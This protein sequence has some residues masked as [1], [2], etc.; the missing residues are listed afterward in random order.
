[1]FSIEALYQFRRYQI[2]QEAASHDV[3]KTE[4][5]RVENAASATIKQAS[6]NHKAADPLPPTSVETKKAPIIRTPPEETPLAVATQPPGKQASENHKAADPQPLPLAPTSPET[7]EAPMVKTIRVPV[8]APS[9]PSGHFWQARKPLHR[10]YADFPFTPWTT[11]SIPSLLSGASAKTEEKP[12]S[13]PLPLNNETMTCCHLNAWL[14]LV[15]TNPLLWNIYS[16]SLST[17]IDTIPMEE[18]LIS[19]ATKLCDLLFPPINGTRRQQDVAETI[20]QF[21]NHFENRTATAH[22][23]IEKTY[24][25]N[26]SFTDEMIEEELNERGKIYEKRG[27]D[28]VIFEEE[29]TP[30]FPFLAIS[31][32]PFRQ[33][34]FQATEKKWMSPQKAAVKGDRETINMGNT[35]ILT[36][37]EQSTRFSHAPASLI[38]HAERNTDSVN[39]N[40]G[41]IELSESMLLPGRFFSENT[42][43]QYQLRGFIVHLSHRRPNGTYSPNDGHYISYVKMKGEDGQM[44]YYRLD[45]GI[46]SK[47][48]HKTLVKDPQREISQEEFLEAGK[49][50]TIAIYNKL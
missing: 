34:L 27:N 14:T 36:L 30:S 13:L 23:I 8:P 21:F 9:R 50:F 49:Q 48:G 6:E 3:S 22:K 38:F 18:T 39:K 20:Q 45:D 44:H 28:F 29:Q 37:G 40:M 17:K 1:M 43:S 4:E 15:Q 19:D 10:T 7:I 41:E 11:T 26:E 31:P 32:N 46:V 5:R 16:R 35:P 47:D 2:K 12:Q 24:R 25:K 42:L 33:S